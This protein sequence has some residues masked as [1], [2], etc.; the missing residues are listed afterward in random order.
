LEKNRLMK[1]FLLFLFLCFALT[2]NAQQVIVKSVNLLSN[3]KA[4]NPNDVTSRTVIMLGTSVINDGTGGIF[5]FSPTSTA[6]PDDVNVVQSNVTSNGRWIRTT[7]GGGSGQTVIG[8]NPDGVTVNDSIL[9]TVLA[10]MPD[11]GVL[12]FETPGTYIFD[13]V[14]FSKCISIELGEG[15]RF[16]HKAN[17]TGNMFTFTVAPPKIKGGVWDGNMANQ[18]NNATNWWSL[19]YVNPSSTAF[20]R[21]R[22]E[23]STFTNFVFGGTRF[24][25]MNG[26]VEADHCN[27]IEGKEHGGVLGLQSQGFWFSETALPNSRPEVVLTY[28]T[29]IQ[30]SAP[31]VT[32]KNPGGAIFGGYA[33]DNIHPSVKVNHCY[34]KGTGQNFALNSIGSVDLYEDVE[35]AE[36]T[37][38]IFEDCYYVPIKMQNGSHFICENNI[39]VG[40]TGEGTQGIW[41]DPHQRNDTT[42]THEVSTIRGNIVVRDGTGIVVAGNV[43]HSSKVIVENNWVIGT[44]VNGIDLG[45]TSAGHTFSGPA[46]IQGNVILADDGNGIHMINTA[47]QYQFIGNYSSATHGFLATASNSNA[48][49]FLS[50]NYFQGTNGGYAASIWGVKELIADSGKYNSSA[51]V[52]IKADDDGNQIQKLQWSDGNILDDGALDIT[53]SGVDE[54]V[55]T[56][57]YQSVPQNLVKAHIGVRYYCTGNGTIWFKK[58]GTGNTGW[59]QIGPDQFSPESDT[60][61]AFVWNKAD[62]STPVFRIDTGNQAVI[63]GPANTYTGY[64]F[65]IG[66][67]V[68]GDAFLLSLKNATPAGSAFLSLLSDT[69]QGGLAVYSATYG[70]SALQDKIALFAESNA[71]ALMLSAQAVGQTIEVYAGGSTLT[72]KFDVD[73]FKLG[74]SRRINL[75][76]VAGDVSSPQDGDIWYNSSTGFF[77]KRQNGVTSNMDTSG[78]GT[79]I[80]IKEEDGTPTGTFDTIKFPNG[81]VTDNGD[82]SASVAFSGG[83]TGDDLTINGTS[84]IN[85]DFQDTSTLFWI[86]DTSPVPDTIKAYP[87]NLAN[88]QIAAGANIAASKLDSSVILDTEIDTSAEIAS[89]VIDETGTG[90]LVFNLS[91]S[92]SSPLLTGT[93][94]LGGSPALAANQISTATTGFIFEGSTADANETLLTVVDPTAD[95]TITLPN[96][97]GT[98]ILDTAI[99]TSSE[100]ATIVTDETGSG[101]LVF[102]TSPTLG[103]PTL[104]TPTVNDPVWVGTA[105]LAGNPAFAANSVGLGTTGFIFEGATANTFEGLLTAADVTADRTWTLPDATGTIIVDTAIDTSSELAGIIGDETG[106]G[107]LVFGTSPTIATPT[108]SGAITF[109]SNVRQIFAPGATVPGFNTGSRAGDPSSLSNGDMW[110]DSTANTLKARINGSTVSLAG[111]SGSGDVTAASAFGFDNRVVRTDGTG[112]GVQV[113]GVTLDDSDN[114]NIPGTLTVGSGSG[115]AEVLW[116]DA[117]SSNS[118]RIAAPTD[119]TGN[120]NLILAASPGSGGLAVYTQSAVTNLTESFVSTLAGVESALGAINIIQSTEIDTSSELAGI[121]GDETGTGALVFGTAPAIG[122]AVLTDPTITGTTTIGGN[123]SLAANRVTYGTTGF[124]FEGSTADANETLLTV[125]DPTVDRTITLP[126]ATGTVILDSAIDTSSELAGIV[127]D[128]TG[129]GSLVF[130]TSPTL[131]TPII[132]G[133]ISFPDGV[134]QTFNPN[135]TTPGFNVGAQAGDPSSLSDGDVWYDSTGGLLRARIN[136]ATVSLAAAGTLV[137]DAAFSSAWNSEIGNAPSRNAVYDWG[138]LFDTDDDGKVN[139]LDMGAGIVKTDSGGVVSIATAGTDYTTPSSTETET[140]KTFDAAGTGNTLKTTGYIK[141]SFPRTVDGSGCTYVNTNDFT[142]ATF[143][144]PRFSASAATNVN[145]CRFGFRVPKDF[146]SSVDLTASLTVNLAGDDTDS[147]VF[148]VGVVSVANS[149]AANATAANYAVLTIPSDA[150]GANGDQESVENVTLTGWKSALTAGQWCVVELRRSGADN[151]TQ[152]SYLQELEITYG[153]TQ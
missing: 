11:C 71:T 131:I 60:S 53:F 139:V 92:I 119:I 118:Y 36:I 40:A 49:I 57:S 50:G 43:A 89:L 32:G 91:P 48:K 114:M 30:N 5:Y 7:I 25:Q 147:S 66:E 116:Y 112:K 1:K 2:A 62:A 142:T 17:A 6:T 123:P 117:D 18:N 113:S 81:T 73:G 65:N 41:F 22:I 134:R 29:F 35:R 19:V 121:I 132:S 39:I 83:G 13:T 47:G 74:A 79:T 125:V 76:A 141:L 106:T 146:D 103:T 87:T 129:S 61:T 111:G 21:T 95:R 110:Y 26:R 64:R 153:K 104:N 55:G 94:T 24:F 143:M 96:A 126:D 85:P 31:S 78:A 23:G 149:S 99:D 128:E 151:S 136:G 82:G 133:V 80:T 138:H 86:L 44:T 20:Q 63:T 107:A 135:A 34:F 152:P 52:Q 150:S 51:G 90:V 15:V 144:V 93:F 46:I 105:T 88:A 28:C 140:N 137:N 12:R 102:G 67:N 56:M 115:T 68:A 77:R 120:I 37:E 3:L 84:L 124:I 101:A 127:G 148:H 33:Q 45:A 69:A 38:N 70:T 100:I 72:A 42:E 54:L 98:V 16:K 27:F 75:G 9:E 108:I 109:P 58:T 122:T 59:A 97:S 14:T 145:F 130:G 4:F 10:G 8:L